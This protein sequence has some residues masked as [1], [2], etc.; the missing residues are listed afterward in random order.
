M[1]K[2]LIILTTISFI[3]TLG[4]SSSAYSQSEGISKENTISLNGESDQIQPRALPAVAAAG[5][6]A[7]RAGKAAYQAWKNVPAPEKAMMTQAARSAISL[8]GKDNINH[9]KTEYYFD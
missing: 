7:A 6:V 1:K 8:G 3:A 9:K 2:M 5:A 4:V